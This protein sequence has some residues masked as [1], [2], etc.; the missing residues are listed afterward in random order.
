MGVFLHFDSRFKAFFADSPRG[1]EPP[2]PVECSTGSQGAISMGIQERKQREREIR[3]QQIMVAA[4]RIFTQ[5]GY[6]KSTMEDIATEAEL[7]PGTLYLYFRSKDELY[8]SLCLRVLQYINIKV[9]AV[10]DQAGGDYLSKQR[11]LME[12]MID[13]YEYDP[14]ILNNMFHLQSSDTLKA[15]SPDLLDD[16]NALARRSLRAMAGMFSEGIDLGLVIDRNPV[17]LADIVWS[18]FS[19]IV[20]WENSKK[21]IN[22]DRYQLHDTFEA[23]LDIF[24]RG[25]REPCNQA[26]D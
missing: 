16:I 21:M 5:K 17:A 25:L 8:A 7:S 23:A 2:P 4:K 26:A 6:E 15:L 20:L 3:R 13:V 19:G 10:V 18:L 11:A 12:A 14:L 1:K 9:S 22:E 24:G